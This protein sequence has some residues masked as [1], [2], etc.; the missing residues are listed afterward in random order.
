[1]KPLHLQTYEG[2][3]CHANIK[4]EEG[5]GGIKQSFWG[6]YLKRELWGCLWELE[7]WQLIETVRA[8]NS[9]CGLKRP[10]GWWL[11]KENRLCVFVMPA[12]CLHPDDRMRERKREK[13]RKKK[14]R[15]G[16]SKA[17]LFTRQQASRCLLPLPPNPPPLWRSVSTARLHMSVCLFRSTFSLSLS[18]G[19][20]QNKCGATP[21]D[22][23]L[24]SG[25]SI[26][27]PPELLP[28]A[29]RQGEAASRRGG[30]GGGLITQAS[31]TLSRVRGG[32]LGINVNKQLRPNEPQ[33][34]NQEA[35]RKS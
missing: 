4:N 15:R 18:L 1:M 34:S 33:N 3:C 35:H 16:I 9:G 11:E 28:A 2:V 19:F 32:S 22:P 31:K 21:T 25:A 17:P 30:S 6:F 13:E 29:P 24:N 10:G 12:H 23:A 26:S 27:H 20:T 7:M 14:E 5:A 8:K